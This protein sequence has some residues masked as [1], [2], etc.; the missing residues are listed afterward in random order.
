VLYIDT[1]KDLLGGIYNM[2]FKKP[3]TLLVLLT[4]ILSLIATTYGIFSSGGPGPYN[5]ISI[6]GQT[7]TIYGRGVYGMNSVS[8]ALQ[9]IPQDIIT[10][11]LGIPFLLLSLLLARRGSI[12][13]RLLLG[14]VLGYFLITY[15]MYTFIAMYN[16]LFIVYV[17]LISL[18][19]FA[20]ILTLMSFEL[21]RFPVY[22]NKR[23]PVKFIGGCLLFTTSMIGYLWIARVLPTLIN[24]FM[25]P[26]LE[27]GTTLPVQALDLAIF[28][29]S[30]FL[31]ALLL[32]KG[33][34]LGYL[35]STISTFT[36]VL[37]MSALLSKGFS[38]A[39]AGI[40]GTLPMIVM[41]SLFDLL[42]IISSIL[43][44]N[45]IEDPIS[46]KK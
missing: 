22:F 28:L 46:I 19:F 37:M 14:G 11:V 17:A 27:H 9:A 4:V 32:L 39:L 42:A 41:M 31:S 34:P 8:A 7:I 3:I 13:G 26:E 21:N 36:L 43:V 10:L 6:H 44:L 25:P 38:L 35:L 18:N 29:P 24:G 40:P 30:I 23:L 45:N 2:P 5:F 12:K 20:F 16:R 1:Q 15:V 33:N